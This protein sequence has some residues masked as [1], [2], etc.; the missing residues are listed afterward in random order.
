MKGV[1]LVFS[2]MRP[3]NIPPKHGYVDFALKG[4]RARKLFD[5]V[6]GLE[7]L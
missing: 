4:S 6:D 1:Y 3:I 5:K 7:I 2:Q